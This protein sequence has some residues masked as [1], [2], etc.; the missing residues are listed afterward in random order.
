MYLHFYFVILLRTLGCQS[1]TSAF[2]GQIIRGKGSSGQEEG[3]LVFFL[4][5]EKK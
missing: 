3:N 4:K 1:S 5:K 2:V